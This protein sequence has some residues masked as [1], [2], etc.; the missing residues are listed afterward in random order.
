MFFRRPLIIKAER[1]IKFVMKFGKWMGLATVVTMVLPCV[2]IVAVVSLMMKITFVK[3]IT[4]VDGLKM[5]NRLSAI[6]ID[7]YRWSTRPGRS[8]ARYENYKIKK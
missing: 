6:A 2:V 4:H 3:L 5:W 7:N 8:I 1:G